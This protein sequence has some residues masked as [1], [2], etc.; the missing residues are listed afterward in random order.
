MAI[1][2]SASISGSILTIV[3]DEAMSYVSAGGIYSSNGTLINVVDFIGD[4]TSTW[5]MTL[6]TSIATTDY[7]VGLSN[8]NNS[9][10]TYSGTYLSQ[11][12]AYI[13]STGNN[14]IPGSDGNDVIFGASGNDNIG[15]GAGNDYISGNDGNDVIF[16]ASGNDNIGGGAGNDTLDGGLGNDT[17]RYV[18]APNDVTVNLSI[19]SA[20][21]TIGE[22]DTIANFENLIGSSYNDTLTGTS[23]DN[24][25]DGGNGTD[26]AIYS[27]N[28]S[29][30]IVVKNFDGSVTITDQTVSRDGTDTLF[31][32]E[33]ITFADTT[34]LISSLDVVLNS[35]PV[36]LPATDSH[37]S[38]NGVLVVSIQGIIGDPDVP[39]F[40]LVNDPDANGVYGIALTSVT[41][42]PVTL[43]YSTTGAD[44]GAVWHQI[45]S[46][47]L[48]TG[49]L[50]LLAD[51][52]T[53]IKVVPDLG[54]S[55]TISN[56]SALVAWDGSN[57]VVNGTYVP[58][59]ARGGS[60]AYSTYEEHPNL[61]VDPISISTNTAPTFGIGDGKI[62]TIFGSSSGATSVIFQPDGKILAAGI[63][64]GD[65]ALARYGSDGTLDTTF[66]EDGKVTTDM[67]GFNDYATSVTIQVDGKIVVA[68]QGNN[69][70]VLARYNSDGSLDTTFDGDGKVETD[71]GSSYEGGYSVAVQSDK[72]ILVGGFSNS[73]FAVG[74][75]NSD[76]SLDATFGVNGKVI[77][78][79]NSTLDV[80]LSIAVQADGKILTAGYSSTCGYSCGK[81]ALVR[82]NSDGTLDTT[83]DSDGKVITSVGGSNDSALSV[84]LQTDGKI[85]V[86]G[87][88]Y[89]G[90][91]YD[92][93]LVRYN[94]DGSL[95]TTFDSDGKVTTPIGLGI[96]TGRSV[97]LQADGKIIVAGDTANGSN[98]DFALVRYN[99]DG[100]LDTTF[101]GDG[102]VTTDFG[103][104]D[105]I[106]G[107]TVQEDGKIVVAGGNGNFVLARYN[108]D[109]SLDTSFDTDILNG[110]PTFI[111]KSTPIILDGDVQIYD[112]ELSALGNYGGATL[113][114]VRNGGNNSAD[115]FSGAGI[116]AGQANGNIVASETT[117]GTYSYS[118]GTLVLTFN[119]NATQTLVHQALQSIAYSNTGV[120]PPSS[121]QI[122]W[123]FND[124]NTG[125]QGAG[126]ALGVTGSTTVNVVQIY[127]IGNTLGNTL[128]GNEWDN[129][130][131]GGVG[132]DN[133]NGGLGDDT[134]YI[135][136]KG[137]IITEAK[138]EGDDSVYSKI[139][140]TL[141]ANI[142]NLTLEGTASN[143]AYGNDLDNT[144]TG[145]K[146]NNLLDG[147][148]G[149]DTMIGGLGKDIYY[150]DNINDT[151]TET[152]T[153]STEI[154]TVNSSVS[155][156]LGDNVENL[157]LTAT[158]AVNATG[159]SL[160]N[161]LLGNSADNILNGGEGI[162]KM[163]GG[164]GD[165]TCIVDNTA[166]KVTE[167]AGE[168]TDTI[169]TSLSTYS[170]AK[171]AAVENLTYTE[172]SNAILTGNALANILTGSTG[173]DTL[174]GGLGNDTL[175][176]GAGNDIFKFTSKLGATNIDTLSDFNAA[177]DTIQL[178][179]T[180][181]KA[182]TKG[183]TADN[184]LVVGDHT[185][186]ANDYIIYEQTTGKLYYDADGSA[187]KVQ[188]VQI[189]IIGITDH[190]VLTFSDFLAV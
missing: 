40:H 117:V 67:G 28:A 158:A 101:G 118:S 99:S 33:Q 112:A 139:S 177:D 1:I 151:V 78:D 103:T 187:I 35:A 55:G 85:L 127:F 84:I 37:V 54:Y 75:Y 130:L 148:L 23:G 183:F 83:F 157:T 7:I 17:L 119:M 134:Y 116:V 63:N 20:Q 129:T 34:I 124:G 12:T 74:R 32:M 142:E 156:T 3:Y 138:L 30:Y 31:N 145:N 126:G 178:S 102:K 190:P 66:S 111:E 73:N 146:G 39:D 87:I 25:I 110:T 89:T 113:T 107:V 53:Y 59:T 108:S 152:S 45:T 143:K 174:D 120:N 179:K 19:I 95:D 62:T 42:A 133:M 57:G 155:Y 88:S 186:D 11:G 9:V 159:N 150:V 122:D 154:D 141:T 137:D 180:I 144:L 181:F 140:Y 168:G 182:L 136:N 76:G 27:G 106:Q 4:G 65:F 46:Q 44:A 165:D 94:S 13:G 185:A 79:F 82:Y 21:Y 98:Y 171:L 189:A 2:T 164:L 91:S 24:I 61:I 132:A 175:V 38:E 104:D 131:N 26:T 22:W 47:N 184:F 93:A 176:G 8:G 125:M 153:L 6:N 64:D 52:N 147:G 172:A 161:I 56:F 80:I 160:N 121:V 72:K 51:G 68:G 77:T 105:F 71:F 166:D 16:G 70:F 60:T 58:I 48:A 92:F 123:I 167:K 69:D 115:K 36:L 163:T 43:Y 90:S 50:H 173:N 29:G 149:A 135:D 162:D 10:G 97:A 170:I 169:Q 49:A 15:G 96:D 114:L 41:T 188:A 18:N 109:G 86:A 100:S 5:T 81:F 128:I 14:Y